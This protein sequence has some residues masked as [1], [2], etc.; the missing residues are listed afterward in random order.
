MSASA[1]TFLPP[2]SDTVGQRTAIYTFSWVFGGGV[3]DKDLHL[4]EFE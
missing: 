4:E 3:L 1:I 2:A